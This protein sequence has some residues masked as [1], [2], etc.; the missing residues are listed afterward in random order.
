MRLSGVVHDEI[1]LMTRTE[2]AEKW[3]ELLQKTMEEAEAEWLGPVPP[4]A[5][6]KVGSSWYQA[7]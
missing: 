2:I 3:A 4:L 6:A 7:K 5:E 1:I